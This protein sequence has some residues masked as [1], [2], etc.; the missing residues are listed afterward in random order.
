MFS[1]VAQFDAGL[2][3]HA[4]ESLDRYVALGMRHSD[5][6]LLGGMLELFVAANLIDF[7]PAIFLQF[8]DQLTAVHR[9]SSL[10]NIRTFY[11]RIN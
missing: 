9:Q 6:T 10:G 11:T 3:F 1:L 7:V 8:S 4:F 2:S 5:T